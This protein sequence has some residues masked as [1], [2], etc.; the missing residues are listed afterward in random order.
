[1]GGL[2]KEKGKEEGLRANL[3]FLLPLDTQAEQRRGRTGDGA[4]GSGSP[5]HG[6]GRG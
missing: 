4:M 5:E 1:V 2:L 6:G 3:P